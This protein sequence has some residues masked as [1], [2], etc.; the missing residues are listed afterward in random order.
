MG[1]FNK[2]NGKLQSHMFCFAKQNGYMSETGELD[3]EGAKTMMIERLKPRLDELINFYDYYV[4]DRTDIEAFA[5]EMMHCFY[6]YTREFF[7]II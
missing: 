7:K 4:Q 5:V 2:T 3:K 6:Y 1:N